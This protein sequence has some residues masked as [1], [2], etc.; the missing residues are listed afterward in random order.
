MCER[1]VWHSM[2]SWNKGIFGTIS[3][4]V[5]IDDQFGV[6]LHIQFHASMKNNIIIH[7]LH[8][9]KNEILSTSCNCAVGS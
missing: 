2:D 3:E 4:L 6:Q 8:S 1:T 9:A 7:V 5:I